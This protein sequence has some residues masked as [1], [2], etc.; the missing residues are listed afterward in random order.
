MRRIT[1]PVIEFKIALRPEQITLT[2]GE[3]GVITIVVANSGN[4]KSTVQLT[5]QSDTATEADEYSFD[6]NPGDEREVA[7]SFEAIFRVRS[8]KTEEMT[9]A[10]N[11]TLT[12]ADREGTTRTRRRKAGVDVKKRTDV[13]EIDFGGLPDLE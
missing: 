3:V 4:V 1:Q 2:E 10:V 7:H 9:S 5:V 8:D 13:V 11:V 6:L 12:Y